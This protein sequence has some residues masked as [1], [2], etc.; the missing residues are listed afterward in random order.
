[1]RVK[2][3]YSSPKQ[4]M[5]DSVSTCGMYFRQKEGNPRWE[6]IDENKKEVRSWQSSG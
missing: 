6:V 2:Y 1:M 4:K 3:I 5:R